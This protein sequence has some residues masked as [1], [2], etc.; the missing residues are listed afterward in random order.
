MD[1]FRRKKLTDFGSIVAHKGPENNFDGMKG[2]SSFGVADWEFL[3]FSMACRGFSHFC[4][5]H[6]LPLMCQGMLNGHFP[7][8]WHNNNNVRVTYRSYGIVLLLSE[9]FMCM[10]CNLFCDSFK[11]RTHKF[12]FYSI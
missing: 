1:I 8:I 3:T 5:Y 12:G 4:K 9:F 11:M 6:I 10:F 2:A 7:F